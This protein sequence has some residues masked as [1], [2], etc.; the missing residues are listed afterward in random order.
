M[1]IKIEDNRLITITEAAYILGYKSYRSVSKLI[2]EGF[3]PTY[4]LPDTKRKRV[5]I[6]EVMNLAKIC[7]NPN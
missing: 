2:D 1:K 3:L 5:R 7:I 4:S 6:Q